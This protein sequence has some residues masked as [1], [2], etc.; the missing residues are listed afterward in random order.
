MRYILCSL[1]IAVSYSKS[2]AQIVNVESRRVQTDTTGWFGSFGTGFLFEK[3]V[4]EV[5]NINA[6]AY[7]EYQTPKSVFIGM[8]SYNFLRGNGKSLYDNTFYHVRYNYKINKWLHWEAFT[9]LQHNDIT[10]IKL[11]RLAGTGPRFRIA[12]SKKISLHVA[13]AA[14]Y[15]YEREKTDP[16]I[17]HNDIR[18][19]SYLSLNFKP[20]E[21][22]SLSGTVFYQPL[23]RNA[24]DYRV[25]NE[26]K[27]KFKIVKHLSFKV[28]WY[29]LHDSKP[30]ANTP[31]YNY[32][33]SNGVEYS[34]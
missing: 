9:Q 4:L 33:I 26:I 19:T 15:E 10:G 12:A 7:L 31:K 16:V 32:S 29:Y 14:M 30:A 6:D 17:Y 27:A 1:I 2:F 13:T 8:G 22:V 18:S 25:L 28:T 24:H 5:I 21:N 34:F 23:F 3:N 20:S 11:R